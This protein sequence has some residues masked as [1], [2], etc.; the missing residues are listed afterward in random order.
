MKMKNLTSWKER[1]ARK[2]IKPAIIGVAVLMGCASYVLQ[3][4]V[5]VRVAYTVPLLCFTFLLYVA[6]RKHIKTWFRPGTATAI[7]IIALLIPV[8]VYHTLLVISIWSGNKPVDGVVLMK[9]LAG[10]V[11]ISMVLGFIL[12]YAIYIKDHEKQGSRV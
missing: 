7:L 4:Y 11:A 2:S 6:Y 8:T 9:R 1:V 5:N 10:F 12:R 3:S